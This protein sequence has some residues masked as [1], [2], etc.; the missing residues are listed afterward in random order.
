MFGEGQVRAEVSPEVAFLGSLV[1][2]IVAG[3]I[4]VPRF[5]RGFVWKQQDLH[6]L[7]DSVFRGFPI[8]SVLVWDTDM[9]IATVSR[10]GPVQVG[11]APAGTVGYLLDGQQ[12]LS[13]L[14]G[15]LRLP[16]Q[17]D[18]T[19]DQVD[20][21][22]CC[23]LETW[24]F[25]RRSA[26]EHDPQ[27]FPMS[28]LLDTTAFFSACRRIM[29][30]TSDGSRSH[31]WLDRADRLANAFRDYQIP[32]IHV[33]EA[34]LD[35]AVMVFAR[36][37]RTGR[38]MAADEM[39]SALT[40]REGKFHLA[41]ELDQIKHELARSRFSNLDRVLLLRSVLAALDRDIYAK[42]WTD[43][44]VKPEVRS[45]L[46]TS[47]ESAT[48][49]IRGAVKF[50]E[51][52]GVASDR[53]LPYGLQLVLLGEFF[54]LCPRPD[55]HTRNL[56]ERWFWVTSFTGWFGGVSTSQAT[57]ALREIR[58]LAN[59][60]AS[61]VKTVN[62]E[63]PAQPF[64][65]RFDGRSAR[66]RA[67][68]LY[69]AS[70]CPLTLSGSEN[71]DPG[72]LLSDRGTGA[73]VY[74]APGGDVCKELRSSPANRMFA[75]E[76]AIFGAL[77]ALDDDRLREIL[78]THGFPEESIELLREGDREGLI[79]ARRDALIEGERAFLDARG[80]TLP[81]RRTAPAIADSD[82]SD[83]DGSMTDGG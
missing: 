12:R 75:D 71:L 77:C 26:G 46:P 38:K 62:L 58:D 53:L 5:Q 50:L 79:R 54:R 43:L 45:K 31:R 9:E 69:L 42:D 60:T 55:D 1:E 19:F 57:R 36:L 4:R 33:R 80:V 65:E 18:T 52:L 49:G 78:P 40:Y 61:E 30:H 59:G 10:V 67:F 25:R 63:A 17:E 11:P 23:D 34:D 70:L 48:E 35:T 39:V 64:P 83:D 56:L 82:S 13:T 37:N 81:T 72:R 22:I 8:G 15:A 29:S 47:F 24:E 73:L 66:V 6:A 14:V 76:R 44:L 21:R 16:D 74:L 41:H 32:V 20:W 28:S 3:K 51:R 7:L 68:L 2:R 27:L